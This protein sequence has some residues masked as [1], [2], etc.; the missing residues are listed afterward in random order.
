MKVLNVGSVASVALAAVL[1]IP[2]GAMAAPRACVLTDVSPTAVACQG[3]DSKNLLGGSPADHAATAADLNT[4]LGTNTY[5]SSNDGG[6]ATLS[7]L[8]G[9]TT[10]DFG[11]TLFG[12]TVVGFHNGA[13]KGENNNIGEE[14]T[15]FFLIDFTTPTTSFTLDVPGSS[16][17]TLYSTGSL[18][19]VPEPATWAMMLVGFGGLGA[20]LRSRRKQALAVA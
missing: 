7:N 18:G 19:G 15:A 2:T 9:S 11:M 14:G 17:A 13:A 4:L 8:N 1:A 3:W 5:T 10:I 12:D 16:G 20:M 6:I